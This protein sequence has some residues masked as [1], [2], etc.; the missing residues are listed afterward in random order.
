MKKQLLLIMMLCKSMLLVAWSGS[1]AT[2]EQPIFFGKLTS[3]EGRTFNVT[4]IMIGRSESAGRAVRVYEM[5]RT[6]SSSVGKDTMMIP[7]N[8]YHDLTTT[9]LDLLKVKKIA[10][11]HPQTSWI[12]EKP[13]TDNRTPAM[14]YEFIELEITWYG[15]QP[16]NYLL[17]L[18]TEHTTKPVKIFCDSTNN[19]VA[20]RMATDAQPT[21]CVGIQQN[22]LRKKGA[23]FPAIK[24][25]VI[26]G[27]C[28][29]APR[30]NGPVG[31]MKSAA[32]PVM[33]SEPMP[34]VQ[35]Q[36]MQA[37]QPEQMPVMKPVQSTPEME[38]AIKPQVTPTEDDTIEI[39]EVV[40]VD[41]PGA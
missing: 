8:P 19:A 9:E 4:N 20:P 23:P 13:S 40:T 22:E 6:P 12:W 31:V 21:F 30:N 38:S 37:V 24:E 36:P 5:P 15:S 10:V 35:P 27:H 17:E 34:V 25:L 16:C 1:N 39:Q 11:P 33:A 14:R 28:Y 2:G 26:E 29:E 32:Q 3:H 41:E 7:V 18:G